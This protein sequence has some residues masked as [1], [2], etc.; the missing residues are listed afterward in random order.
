MREPSFLAL[1]ALAGGR[2]H[3]YALLREVEVVSGG[4]VRL[5]V[6]SLYAVLERLLGDGLVAIDGEEQFRGRLRRYFVLT[7]EGR[8]ALEAETDRLE[9]DARAARM[10]LA[11]PLVQP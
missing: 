6:G 11:G 7:D 4:R 1:V 3:G 2:S 8:A 5:Q 10:R 9:A